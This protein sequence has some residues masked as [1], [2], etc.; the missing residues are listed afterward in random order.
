[1]MFD[2]ANIL[3]SGGASRACNARCPYCI[4]RQIDPHLNT[5]NLDQYPPRNLD[6]F[7]AL[8]DRHAI[9]QVVFSGTNT[10]PQLY[11]HEARLINI[12]RSALPGVQL[13]LHTNGRLALKKMEVFNR[14]DR[15]SLSLPTFDPA[16]YRRMMGV[17]RPPDLAQIL[18]R[19]QVP[20]KVSCVVTGDNGAGMRE[21]LEACQV[22]GIRRVVL[23]KLYGERRTWRKLLPRSRLGLV[24]RGAFRGNP[25]YDFYGMEVTLWDFDRAQVQSINLFSTGE[26]STAY[27]LAQPGVFEVPVET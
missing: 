21:F 19:A 2:F 1:M 25:V 3:F 6:Q 16:A 13:A 20:V 26:I 12:L 23:R 18:R 8:I 4:G 22:L 7:I 15:V 11:R 14:Y 17:P 27:L 10:D 9:P 24:R 5:H